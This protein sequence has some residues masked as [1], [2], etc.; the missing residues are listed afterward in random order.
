MDDMA[1]RINPVVSNWM[2]PLLTC[3][4][5]HGCQGAEQGSSTLQIINLDQTKSSMFRAKPLVGS[6]GNG[7]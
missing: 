1:A 3:F 6:L 2:Q 5:S 4:G 7:T